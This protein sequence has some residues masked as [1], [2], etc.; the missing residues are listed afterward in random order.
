MFMSLFSYLL[1]SSCFLTPLPK[2]DKNVLTGRVGQ[3]F[4][5]SQYTSFFSGINLWYQ[6][7]SSTGWLGIQEYIF[8]FTASWNYMK[9]RS[10]TQPTI[11]VFCLVPEPLSPISLMNCQLPQWEN[12]GTEPISVCFF[13]L[14]DSGL[15]S[16]GW[17]SSPLRLSKIFFIFFFWYFVYIL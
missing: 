9:L 1:F 3:W 2:D 7:L 14:S 6:G 13:S 8:N 16:S 11:T 5:T 15:L 12:S 17:L 10:V 4:C